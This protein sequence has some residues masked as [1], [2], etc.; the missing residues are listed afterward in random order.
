[1]DRRAHTAVVLRTVWDTAQDAQEF[2]DAMSD[3]IGDTGFVLPPDGVQVDVGFAS[4][5]ATLDTLRG[6]L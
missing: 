2:A 4:D 3:W 6:A 5:A 1:M